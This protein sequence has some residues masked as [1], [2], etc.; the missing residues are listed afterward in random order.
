[1]ISRNIGDDEEEIL[2]GHKAYQRQRRDLHEEERQNCGDVGSIDSYIGSF[3]CF[4]EK[5]RQVY[6]W[7]TKQ[8][9]YINSEMNAQELSRLG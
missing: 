8:F 2:T 4:K 5:G 3:F 7:K 1:M 6:E 9:Q